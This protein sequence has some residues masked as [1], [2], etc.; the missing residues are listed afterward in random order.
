MPRTSATTTAEKG[1]Q[2]ADRTRPERALISHAKSSAT[3]STTP[4]ERDRKLRRNGLDQGCRPGSGQHS[5]VMAVRSI[6]F[7]TD[8][9]MEP[10]EQRFPAEFNRESTRTLFAIRA[11][12]H[13][14]NEEQNT[15]LAPFGLNTA[16][17]NYLIALYGSPDYTLTQNQIRRLMH[18]SYAS[19]TKMATSLERDGLVERAKNP[20]DGRSMSLK[21]TPKG[22]TT[23][24][25]ALPFHHRT[26]EDAMHD[27]TSAERQQLVDL[28]V[29]I[30]HGFD[31]RN[32]E[33][34]A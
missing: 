15:W 31:R 29:K 8:D 14:I 10:F 12:A 25:R 2:F 28:L 17:Y 30:S 27:V 6:I 34:K 16:S 11:L 23:M 5:P 4:R 26:I 20:E 1:G 24:E 33:R 3:T 22:I 32:A 13:R 21:L 7:L 19:V 9:I 18:T